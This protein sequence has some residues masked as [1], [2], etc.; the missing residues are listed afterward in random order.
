MRRRL[1]QVAVGLVVLFAA[2][3]TASGLVAVLGDGVDFGHKCM[4]WS[5]GVSG[6]LPS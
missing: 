5:M 2:V 3:G 1:K 6:R 4:R